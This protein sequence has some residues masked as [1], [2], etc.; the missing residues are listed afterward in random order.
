MYRYHS[1][2]IH[3]SA[4]G[5]LG[6]IEV[7]TISGK[8]KINEKKKKRILVWVAISSSR[9]SSQPK[10]Q[11]CISY[12]PCI[13]RWFLY[14]CATWEAHFNHKQS[15]YSFK[16][17]DWRWNHPLPVRG[18]GAWMCVC[19]CVCVYAHACTCMV[20][21]VLLYTQTASFLREGEMFRTDLTPGENWYLNR[22]VSWWMGGPITKGCCWMSESVSELKNGASE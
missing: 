6:Y 19:A 18:P 4:D 21:G 16:L 15:F 3:L 10:D 17:E 12:I 5:H 20:N 2:L 22:L 13:G 8:N 14:H 1:F 9:V 7:Y 11:I